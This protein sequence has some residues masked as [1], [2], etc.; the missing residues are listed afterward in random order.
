VVRSWRNPIGTKSRA[1][2]AIGLALLGVTALLAGCGSGVD[3][4][5]FSSSDRAAAQTAMT[6]LQSSS[7]PVL[8]VDESATAG[9]APAAC[10]VHRQSTSPDTFQIY[11]FWIPFIGPQS[12]AWVTMTVGSDSSRDTFHLGTA[13]ALLPGGAQQANG[14][15]VIPPLADYDTPLADYGSRQAAISRHMLSE[16]AGNAFARPTAKCEVLMNGY[17][18]LKPGS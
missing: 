4:G 1:R 13:P 18:R 14:A 15:A 2:I 17:L 10:E 12:Y 9:R 3:S 11:V 7:I 16:H 5:G 8:L 6:D